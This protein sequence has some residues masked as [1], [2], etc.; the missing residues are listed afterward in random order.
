MT[1]ELEKSINEVLKMPELSDVANTIFQNLIQKVT[2][3]HSEQ[4]GPTGIETEGAQATTGTIGGLGEGEGVNTVG[5][6]EGKGIVEDESGITPIE[7]VRRRIRGG[8][9]IGYDEKA[10]SPLEGWIDPGKPAIIINIAHPAWKVA[11]GLTMQA[12]DERVR[13]YHT[14]RTIFAVLVEE[15][16]VESPKETVARLFSCWYASCIK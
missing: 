6:E 7:R 3:I 10:E 4:G 1:R 13:V 2:A 5:E 15:A 11:E 14:L 12:R 8:I 16:G 9:K